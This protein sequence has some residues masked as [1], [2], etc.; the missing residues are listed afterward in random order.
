M[1]SPVEEQNL[2]EEEVSMNGIRRKP[3]VDLTQ[4]R[5]LRAQS[6]AC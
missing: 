4:S 1:I 3:H 6:E 5:F 2:E